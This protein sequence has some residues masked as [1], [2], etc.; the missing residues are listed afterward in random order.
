MTRVRRERLQEYNHLR[1]GGYSYIVESGSS[2]LL[3]YCRGLVAMAT[4]KSPPPNQTRL[5]TA[6][7]KVRREFNVLY[8]NLSLFV[9][10]QVSYVQVSPMYL[11]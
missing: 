9:F 5:S 10:Q 2:L 7:V 11:L 4:P 1:V 3:Y 8:F 6:P